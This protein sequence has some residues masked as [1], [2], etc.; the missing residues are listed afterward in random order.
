[1]PEFKVP[2]I[3]FIELSLFSP[4]H[5]LLV[6]CP[7]GEANCEKTDEKHDDSNGTVEEPEIIDIRY[8]SATEY[9]STVGDA[10][11]KHPTVHLLGNSGV[12]A[13]I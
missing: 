10:H 3:W 9:V 8:S 11:T 6:V 13:C 7:T 1:M 5:S 2:F 12:C 4:I